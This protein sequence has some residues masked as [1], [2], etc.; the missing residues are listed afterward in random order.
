[1][2]QILINRGSDLTFTGTWRDENGAAMNLTGWAIADYDTVA[3]AQGKI[4][5]QWVNAALGTYTV[6]M[7]WDDAMG[8]SV[9]FRLK[10]SNGSNDITSP[11]ILVVIQ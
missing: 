5:A 6:T 7:Q 11:Q 8:N 3:A 9:Q 2:S 10:I 1:M 4:T